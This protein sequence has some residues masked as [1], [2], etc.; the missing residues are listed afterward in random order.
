MVI[1][2]TR[3]FN[4]RLLWEWLSRESD[5]L[6]SRQSAMSPIVVCGV[7]R[8]RESLVKVENHHS[9][10]FGA[11]HRSLKLDASFVAVFYPTEHRGTWRVA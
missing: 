4:A 5:G 8:H 10:R 2:E 9:F 3:R 11:N 7:E 1:F 6:C